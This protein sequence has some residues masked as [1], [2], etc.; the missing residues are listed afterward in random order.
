ML[1]W[2]T[3]MTVPNEKYDEVI[4]LYD[5]CRLHTSIGDARN[6]PERL[7]G[8]ISATQSDNVERWYWLLENFVVVQGYVYDSALPSVHVIIEALK[9]CNVSTC[10]KLFLYEL[11]YQIVNGYAGNDPLHGNLSVAD[12]CRELVGQHLNTLSERSTQETDELLQ[13][14]KACTVGFGRLGSYRNRSDLGEQ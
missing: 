8:L 11:I 9:H 13:S 3:L 1:L 2:A 4:L 14:I 7:S 5:W 6:I 12:K 10:A